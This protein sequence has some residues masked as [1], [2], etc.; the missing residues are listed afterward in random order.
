MLKNRKCLNL[1]GLQFPGMDKTDTGLLISS[2]PDV[3][4]CLN[5]CPSNFFECSMGPGAQAKIRMDIC[6]SYFLQIEI[7]D[8]TL[9]AKI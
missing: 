1:Y 5:K 7:A 6:R 2:L 4:L 8:E 9:E 3:Q